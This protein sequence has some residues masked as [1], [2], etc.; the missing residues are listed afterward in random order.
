MMSRE[1]YSHTLIIRS[2]AFLITIE[3]ELSSAGRG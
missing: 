3:E 1:Y 2:I